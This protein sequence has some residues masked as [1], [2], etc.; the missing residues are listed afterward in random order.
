MTDSLNF[1]KVRGVHLVHI[2]IRSLWNKIDIFKETLKDS[3][4]TI[5]SISE[6]WLTS[7]LDSKTIAR[8]RLHLRKIGQVLE[9]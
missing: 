3:N 2:N 8:T 7:Q 4:T 5:C 9:R 1:S 6:T